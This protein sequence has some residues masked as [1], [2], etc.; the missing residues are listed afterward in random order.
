MA[1]WSNRL[2]NEISVTICEFN[3]SICTLV[4]REARARGRGRCR[5]TSTS[6]NTAR[7]ICG[8]LLRTSIPCCTRTA[9]SSSFY[10][11]RLPMEASSSTSPVFLFLSVSSSSQTS[12]QENYV[13]AKRSSLSSGSYDV[14]ELL[15]YDRNTNS[16]IFLANAPLPS[17]R[18]IFSTSATPSLA[19]DSSRCVSCVSSECTYQRAEVSPSGRHALVQ[20][21]GPLLQKLLLV[22]LVTQAN[23]TISLSHLSPNELDVQWLRS[24]RTRSTRRVGR[25][26]LGLPSFTTKSCYHM[27][28]VSSL[29]PPTIRCRCVD[30]DPSARRR[31]LAHDSEGLPS[32]RLCVRRTGVADCH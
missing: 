1:V 10:H 8:R 25:P 12:L 15:A 4:G 32:R 22:D 19:G 30:Q 7:L 13:N 14:A 29:S 27:A 28:R 11:R 24:G 26:R 21:A 2:Q 18:H 16:V 31:H 5:V 20:C 6:M 17:Q 23:G 9:S 3:T